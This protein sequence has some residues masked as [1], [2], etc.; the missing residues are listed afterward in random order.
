MALAQ[1]LGVERL[2]RLAGDADRR[3]QRLR[4]AALPGRLLVVAG[5]IRLERRRLL[6]QA[7]QLGA[8]EA[9]LAL[10]GGG[11]LLTVRQPLAHLAPLRA[12]REHG[13]APAHDL[14]RAFELIDA[15]A[16]Q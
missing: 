9:Q 16:Q 5:Q 1:Q 12:L 3:V 13:E 10:V 4:V 8:R 15:L 7:F 11:D 14:P 6:H 2:D